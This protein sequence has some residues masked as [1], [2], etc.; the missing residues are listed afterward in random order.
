MKQKPRSKELSPK[1]SLKNKNSLLFLL[2]LIVVLPLLLW[3]VYQQVRLQPKAYSPTVRTIPS[4]GQAANFDGKTSY[5]A[6]SDNGFT[7]PNVSKDFTIEMYLKINSCAASIEGYSGTGF[8]TRGSV[9][10]GTETPNYFAQAGPY[11]PANIRC[12]IQFGFSKS[13]GLH[14][15]L[16][17]F[18][19]VP[20]GQWQHVAVVKTSNNLKL[21]INGVF[22]SQLA[23]NQPLSNTGPIVY[24]GETADSFRLNGSIDEL[25]FSNIVRYSGDFALPTTPIS[26]DVNTVALYHFDGNLLD[27]SDN[28]RN[29]T[30][31]GNLQFVPSTVNTCKPRPACLNAKP[32][33][34]IPDVGYC[35]FRVVPSRGITP[36]VT[37]PP[38][39]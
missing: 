22:D 12:R 34:K 13:T 36:A 24:I 35:P 30:A 7:L 39:K 26:P 33:C 10:L 6:V 18:S 4:F 1:V 14:Y 2:L 38:S 23:I 15:Y 27:S 20:L 21:F 31:Y 8:M 3:T 11:S 28:G 19:E 9:I 37:L 16:N 5:V 17:S 25:R 32:P 29:G